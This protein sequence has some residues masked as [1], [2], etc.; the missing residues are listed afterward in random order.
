M[1]YFFGFI[2]WLK[3]F[4]SRN[5]TEADKVDRAAGRVVPRPEDTTK[6][7]KYFLDA[8]ALAAK[9]K[10][11]HAGQEDGARNYPGPNAET[12]GDFETKIIGRCDA[13]LSVVRTETIAQLVK[14]E[15]RIAATDITSI[16]TALDIDREQNIREMRIIA[17]IERE[18]LTDKKMAEY[19]ALRDLLYF[20]RRNKR[21]SDPKPTREDWP[22]DL[23]YV[24]VIEA[25]M[26]CVFFK[27]VYD[28]GIFGGL[29]VASVVAFVNVV[30]SF[31]LGS[32]YLKWTHHIGAG[33]KAIGV[34][35]TFLYAV[36][37]VLGHYVLGNYRFALGKVKDGVI[38]QS[39]L[40]DTV[41]A[42]FTHP[43]LVLSDFP[44]LI[45]VML[46]ITLGI[47]AAH[48]G[49]NVVTDPYPGYSQKGDR[50]A[51]AKK[52]FEARWNAV[53]VQIHGKVDEL[54][55]KYDEKLKEMEEKLGLFFRLTRDYE[56]AVE[57]FDENRAQ[58]QSVCASLLN[59][60][61][62]EN[63]AVRT[64]R[65]PGH[66][67]KEAALRVEFPHE[68]LDAS[69]RRE[70]FAAIVDA[71]KRSA[72]MYVRQ[73]HEEGQKIL[74]ELDNLLD[75]IENVADGRSVE[76]V[77]NIHPGGFVSDLAVFRK[78][79]KTQAA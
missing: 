6:P 64:A 52:E 71:D 5:A 74:D 23:G 38:E 10:P 30:G 3:S 28:G 31:A 9:F 62:Q 13:A 46:G 49:K 18:A 76:L 56:A 37:L 61:W 36:G 29:L 77:N 66:F 41:L 32:S 19:A 35:V 15:S 53:R 26:N 7:V 40:H 75:E 67:G 43:G 1:S 42:N 27:E 70:A 45:L 79:A 68:T 44:T 8:D 17:D 54:R 48:W 14:L 57:Y 65:V 20:R 22:E 21:I 34:I 39:A 11:A 33:R 60:Y 72:E 16:D 4:I 24:I 25:I 73:V 12:F 55:K 59:T 69:E 50:Y 58:I 63:E 47:G 2:N 78:K 51:T